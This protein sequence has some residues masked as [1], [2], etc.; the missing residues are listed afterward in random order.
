MSRRNST[1]YIMFG[2]RG[3]AEEY[4]DDVIR[5]NTSI[6]DASIT[7]FDLDA[8]YAEAIIG[9]KVIADEYELLEIIADNE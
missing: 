7:D 2:N 5:S 8:I 4:I 6:L 3:D 9:N 1:E